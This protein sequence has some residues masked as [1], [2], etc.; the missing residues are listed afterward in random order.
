MGV[1]VGALANVEL[2]MILNIRGVRLGEARDG[3]DVELVVDRLL[4][5]GS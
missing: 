3:E 1:N 4:A 5:S 2:L